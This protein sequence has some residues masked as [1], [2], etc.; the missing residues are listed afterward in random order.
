MKAG[1]D[2]VS[3]FDTPPTKKR[4]PSKW[5]RN[6]GIV[7]LIVSIVAV[8]VGGAYWYDQNQQADD[9][10]LDSQQVRE[11]VAKKLDDS[12]IKNVVDGDRAAVYGQLVSLGE[13]A[14]AARVYTDLVASSDDRD[15]KLKLLR[16]YQRVAGLYDNQPH[17]VDAAK[18]YADLLDIYDTYWAAASVAGRYGDDESQKEYLLKAYNASG[19]PESE[20]NDLLAEDIEHQAKLWGEL[21]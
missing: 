13:N 6:L 5:I 21:K 20:R 19:I 18:K 9:Q 15:E 3:S 1:F 17:E 4:T 14:E 16:E 11:N 10:Q 7:I 2:M 8:I 12:E